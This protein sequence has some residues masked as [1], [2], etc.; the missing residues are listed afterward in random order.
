MSDKEKMLSEDI[1]LHEVGHTLGL[2]GHSANPKDVMFYSMNSDN[3][4]T[5]LSARDKSTMARLY[6]PQ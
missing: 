3:P 2:N 6:A 5:A 1:C 4:I